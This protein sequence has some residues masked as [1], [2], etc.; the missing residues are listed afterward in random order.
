MR[1]GFYIKLAWTGM[2]KNKKLYTPYLLTCI[3]MVMMFYIICFLRYSD[4]LR[5]TP[6]GDTMQVM[7]GLG[8]SIMGLFSLIF[9]FYTNSFLIRRRKKE[10]GLYNILGMGKRHLACILLW[11]ALMAAAIALAAGL[12]AGIVFSKFAE[13]GMVRMLYGKTTFFM[14]I[15]GKA[16]V[17]TIRWFLVVF[18][19]IFLNALRQ[20][21]GTNPIQLLRSENVGEKPPKAN[22]FLA[23]AG[24]AILGC[25]YYLAVSIQEPAAVL[26]WFFGAVAMVIVATYLLFVAGSVAACRILQKNKKYYYKANH[27]I[28]VSSMA[29]R[30]K[31]NGAGL[32]SI[33]ILCTMVLVMVSSTACLYIGAEDS[34]RSRYPRNINLDVSVSD[35]S[36]ETEEKI[37]RVREIAKE[38]LAE[39]GQEPENILD[40]RMASFG[41]YMKD[42]RIDTDPSQLYAFQTSTY[43]DIRQIFVVPLEDYNRLMGK[44]EKLERG[45]A[46]LYTTKLGTYQ[47]DEI[48]ID[49]QE[50]LRIKKQVEDFV[51]N[52]VDAMQILPSIHL[53]VPDLEETIRPLLSIKDKRGRSVVGISWNYGFDLNCEDEKQIAIFEELEER[54]AEEEQDD[55]AENFAI[56]CEG[57]AKERAGF[58]G[59]YGGLFFLGILLGVV[60]LFA[61]VLIMYYKQVSE[62]YEDQSRFAIMQNVGMTK[63]EIKRSI[64]SQILTVFFLPL[65]TAGIHLAFAFPMI[66]RLLVLFSLT[67]WR[68]LILVTVCC[69]LVFA[70]FYMLVYRMTSGA[71]YTIVSGNREKQ[72]L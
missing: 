64:N 8:S 17:L 54:L 6:G 12:F 61:A 9:L 38:V 25:A 65:I 60:F 52:G 10:F 58:Y 11:E 62:G 14:S 20:I 43:S 24:I 67:N 49:D 13:L 69:Y 63:K 50:P 44:E 5:S 72:D 41:G 40:Y 23:L 26:F 1:A 22:W 31:R 33:C 53:F 51:D 4:T 57:V 32:A 55:E 70:L 71:Y 47:T 39:N 37:D 15:D 36:A 18:G 56:S 30:M 19:L 68:L 2:R 48:I 35:F 59:L 21:R 66:Y 7:L 27:F 34:L 29:Y 16:I 46:L 42:G 45:E 3:G 28:S